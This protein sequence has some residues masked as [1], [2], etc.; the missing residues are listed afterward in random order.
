MLKLIESLSL[1]QLGKQN[2]TDKAD[3]HNYLNYYESLFAPWKNE[4][5][6]LL[7][8]GIRTGCSIRMWLDYFYRAKIYCVDTNSSYVNQVKNL[9][10]TKAYN[11]NAA[12]SEAWNKL[13]NV[14]F[15]IVIDD[16]SHYPS[17]QIATFENLKS[18]M[19]VK[20]YYIVED[21]H[22]DWAFENERH[23]FADYMMGLFYKGLMSKK[24]RN[25][26]ELTFTNRLMVMKMGRV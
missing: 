21:L 7:E 26:F 9:K 20:G 10:R 2:G 4:P 19:K 15:D 1:H 13:G 25:D 14:K 16:G 11:L 17:Q 12:H 6:N 5:I 23:P 3:C 18:R 24:K 22:A 8:I